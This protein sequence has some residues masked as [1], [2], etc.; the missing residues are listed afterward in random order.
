MQI[1]M[2][3][4]LGVGR[5]L[6]VPPR[7]WQRLIL[8]GSVL[9]LLMCGVFQAKGADKA[10]YHGLGFLIMAYSMGLFIVPIR[11]RTFLSSRAFMLCGDSA[12]MLVQIAALVLALWTLMATAFIQQQLSV[13][14]FRTAF[15][16][17]ALVSLCTFF[18]IAFFQTAFGWVWLVLVGGNSFDSWESIARQL[19][20]SISWL[21]VAA[22]AVS[23]SSWIA[24]Y[25]FA[26]QGRITTN[27]IDKSQLFQSR[28]TFVFFSGVCLS[29]DRFC[30]FLKTAMLTNR[31]F[32][33]IALMGGLA[34]AAGVIFFG[35]L[36]FVNSDAS[37]SDVWHTDLISQTPIVFLIPA[38][39]VMGVST[40]MFRRYR[41]YWLLLPDTKAQIA[42]YVDRSI[43]LMSPIAL[44]P[45]GFIY[46]SFAIAGITPIEKVVQMGVSSLLLS[47]LVSYWLFWVYGQ[48]SMLSTLGSLVLLIVLSAYFGVSGVL[49]ET[50]NPIFLLFVATSIP[51]CLCLRYFSIKRWQDI[52]LTELRTSWPL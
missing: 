17:W 36:E 43:Y 10:L 14:V 40:N 38:F 49:M 20:G 6:L 7:A 16:V 52:D 30:N 28:Q 37:F 13:E 9:V 32:T 24:I 51:A 46:V 15:L 26:I 48:D 29:D 23:L 44:V 33:G 34:V 1:S 27:P 18:L 5:C 3:R 25:K 31:P 47:Y 2:A 22:L 35:L 45:A 21:E 11:M 8:G 4:Y 39:L 42:R 50:D 12:K 19:S 41:S